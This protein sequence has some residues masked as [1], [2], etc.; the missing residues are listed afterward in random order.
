MFCLAF[1]GGATVCLAG[2]KDGLTHFAVFYKKHVEWNEAAE[3]ED[4]DIVF[5]SHLPG[6][7]KGKSE[8]RGS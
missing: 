2:Q 4:I 5:H 6:K 7:N 1:R 8:H 3:V